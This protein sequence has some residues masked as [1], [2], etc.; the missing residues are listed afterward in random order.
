MMALASVPYYRSAVFGFCRSVAL[1]STLPWTPML[2][3]FSFYFIFATAKLVGPIRLPRA[4]LTSPDPAELLPLLLPF[5]P[6]GPVVDGAR[7]GTLGRPLDEI[8]AGRFND[9]PVLMGSVQD[10]GTIFLPEM[11]FIA[12]VFYPL[13]VAGW[14]KLLRHFYNE[15]LAEELFRLYGNLDD[16]LGHFSRISQLLSFTTHPHRGVHAPPTLVPVLLGCL[17]VLE[18]R[19][20]L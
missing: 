19:A 18:I 14:P 13:S 12:G 1:P 16:V 9:V 2:F 4:D 20:M 5:L 6:W 17:F 15:S 8:R 11:P 3:I 7:S 10:E